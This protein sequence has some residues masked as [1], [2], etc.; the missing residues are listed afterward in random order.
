[1]LRTQKSYLKQKTSRDYVKIKEKL[2]CMDVVIY[3]I[4]IIINA[5]VSRDILTQY[6]GFSIIGI[7]V[8]RRPRNIYKNNETH[9]NYK[10]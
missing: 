4:Q 3:E 6:I 9:F 10:I 8:H 2:L 1:M 7:L 5:K